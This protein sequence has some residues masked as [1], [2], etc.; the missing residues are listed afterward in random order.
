MQKEKRDYRIGRAVAK[1]KAAR[2]ASLGIPEPKTY[3]QVDGI[4]AKHIYIGPDGRGDW[5]VVRDGR[6]LFTSAVRWVAMEHF[7]RVKWD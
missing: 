7:D 1:W 6:Q 5:V 3:T 2:C 4:E